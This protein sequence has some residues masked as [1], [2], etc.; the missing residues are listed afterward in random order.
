[1]V[2]RRDA[3]VAVMIAIAAGIA[4]ASPAFGLLHGMS[5]DALTA[6][7]WYAF[8]PARASATSP[9]VIVALDEE[10]YRTPPFAGTPGVFWTREIGRVVTAVIDGGAKVVGFDV[11]FPTS[12]EQ[13][14]LP[15]GDET[16]GAK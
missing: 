15:F 13:S 2:R 7:R 3:L 12:I 16:L 11:V 5:I 9:T 14:E 6:L 10:A 4:A 8:G 1:M